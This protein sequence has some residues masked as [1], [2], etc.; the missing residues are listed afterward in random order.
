LAEGKGSFT[1][2]SGEGNGQGKLQLLDLVITFN[3][4]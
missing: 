4:K 3:L 2:S 1:I